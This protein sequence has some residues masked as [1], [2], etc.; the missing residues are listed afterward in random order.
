MCSNGDLS[1]GKYI[2]QAP[3]YLARLGCRLHAPGGYNNSA[4]RHVADRQV[5]AADYFLPA[6]MLSP[7][8]IQDFTQESE[9]EYHWGYAS[10]QVPCLNDAGTCEVSRHSTCLS[11]R[12]LTL[13]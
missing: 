11:E 12:I 7:R 8:H 6:S 4:S 3:L 10:R 13:Q 9:L 5:W 2:D 1:S